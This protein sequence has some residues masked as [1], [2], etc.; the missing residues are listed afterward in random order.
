MERESALLIGHQP[1]VKAY[2]MEYAQLYTGTTKVPL[3]NK[4]EFLTP[5]FYVENYFTPDEK[6]K[7]RLFEELDKSRKSIFFCTSRFEDK[8]LRNKMISKAKEGIAVEGR[9]FKGF[10]GN[11]TNLLFSHSIEGGKHLPVTVVPYEISEVVFGIPLGFHLYL[12]HS[13]HGFFRKKAWPLSD[14][15]DANLVLVDIFVH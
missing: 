14:E 13:L 3:Q 15:P 4:N 11:L 2:S 6:A 5:D 7:D 1:L 10:F 9:F 12:P 8:S